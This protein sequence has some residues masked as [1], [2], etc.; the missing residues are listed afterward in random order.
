MVA[1]HDKD[2]VTLVMSNSSSSTAQLDAARSSKLY[3]G[4]TLETFQHVYECVINLRS[5]LNLMIVDLERPLVLQ[6]LVEYAGL[7][8][9]RDGRLFFAANQN[10]PHLA[11]HPWQDMVSIFT[12]FA[13]IGADST[14]YKAT[15]RGEPVDLSNYQGP[16]AL[17][18]TLIREARAIL[19]GNG[20]GKWSG[21][22]LVVD[23]FSASPTRTSRDR[24]ASGRSPTSDVPAKR[25][26]SDD[27]PPG[28][29]ERHKENGVLVFDPTS[30]LNRRLPP[31]PVYKK[32]RNARSSE[33]LCM[34]YLTKGFA[35]TTQK[36]KF[37]HV[38]TLSTLPPDDKIAFSKF[39]KDTPGLSWVEGKALPGTV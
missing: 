20:L 16:I 21:T 7:L 30:S 14:L 15:M 33:R 3:C 4:G 19:S 39:V 32:G 12:A 22:P 6:K 36:C 17:A 28:D 2:A 18:D 37:P 35:C 5:V 11:H 38:S 24:V 27:A 34:K 31:C 25:Q 9:T 1:E 13:R 23:W 10:V 29:V 26:R 8:V